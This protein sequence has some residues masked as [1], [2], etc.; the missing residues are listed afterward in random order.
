MNASC[1]CY[2][3]ELPV[4]TQLIVDLN[5]WSDSIH[6]QGVAVVSF[7]TGWRCALGVAKRL[8]K[9]IVNHTFPPCVLCGGKGG[10]RY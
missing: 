10:R 9:P 3:F 5:E 8:D 7:V 1:R 4:K 2:T 6:R